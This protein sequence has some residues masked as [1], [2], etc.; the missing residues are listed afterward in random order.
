MP[1]IER[2]TMAV[3][4]Y[5]R[6]LAEVTECQVLDAAADVVTQ[7]WVAELDRMRQEG[8]RLAMAVR[9]AARIAR[10]QMR[11]AEAG[12][13]PADLARAR[14]RLAETSAEANE[15]LGHANALLASVDAE[16]AAV[17]AAGAERARR[18][19]RNLDRLRSARA[20]AFG[21]A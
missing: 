18:S 9:V 4:A 12:G 1:D 16:L 21:E 20:A 8:L 11:Q 15:S 14:A 6:T 13:R 10:E 7:A 3:R 17:C 19:E 5:E 2:D